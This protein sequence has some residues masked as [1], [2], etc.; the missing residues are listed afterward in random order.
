MREMAWRTMEVQDQRVRFV[1]A[2]SGG[3]RSVS[4]LCREFG[5]SRPTGYKWLSR[6]R[7]AGVA[8]I[9]EHSRRP[10][11]SPKRTA[12]QIERRIGEL[13]RERP[14]WGARKLL[15]LLEGEGFEIPPS[16][17]HRVLLRLGLVREED[18]RSPATSRFEREQP[19][20]LW[21]MDFKSPKGWGTNVGPLSVL[22]D[23]TRYAI[24]LENTG[25][26]RTEAVRER[27]QSAF[28]SY[29]LPDAMLMDHGCPWWNQQASGGWTRLS[30]WL[31]KQSIRLYFSGV[32][33]PQT[34]GKVER[35]HGT[36]EMARRRRGLPEPQLHQRWLDDFRYEYN[37]VRPHEA[38]G[39]KTPASVWH[40]SKRPYD[41]NPPAWQYPE[42]AEVRRLGANGQIT[43]NQR[44][45]QIAGP[46]A[47]EH[48]QLVRQEQRILVFYCQ[49]LIRELDLAASRSTSIQICWKPR[50]QSQA[51][52][53][54]DPEQNITP[55]GEGKD[56][57]YAA[58]ENA[59]RFPLSLPSAAAKHGPPKINL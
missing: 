4:E 45:W 48:V 55:V 46:L 39:M 22:D 58:L 54:P 47:G 49:T 18:R 5:I 27:L 24:A 6:Y 19:N 29:G 7:G 41:A 20:E 38:L 59:T 42:G 34:Q 11:N 57:G 50:P 31:M 21:Q 44:S 10:K 13:R 37:H 14:D 43:L 1:V 52:E 26:T 28:A 35:F 9:R 51:E 3:E 16:T 17:I 25:S 33:H 23:A 8:G 40:A 12:E 30:V 56:V 53:K 36:L 15:R 32:R 2:A